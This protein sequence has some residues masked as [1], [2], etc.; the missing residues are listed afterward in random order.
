[1]PF[2]FPSGAR[3]GGYQ[4][5]GGAAGG[6]VDFASSEFKSQKEDFFSRKQCENASRPE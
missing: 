5:G 1:M 4:N 3:G 6:G 2:A